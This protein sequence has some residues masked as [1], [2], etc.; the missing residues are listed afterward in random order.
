G[1][2][3]CFLSDIDA[4]RGGSAG[5]GDAEEPGALRAGLDAVV[6]GDCILLSAAGCA[7][8]GFRADSC[9]CGGGGDPGGVRDSVD[10][11]RGFAEGG[12]VLEDM[13]CRADDCSGGFRSAGVDSASSRAMVPK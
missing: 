10:A 11:S 7:V 1:C 12:R 3:S 5:G 4:G 6:P 2:G 9:V 13:A 8:C